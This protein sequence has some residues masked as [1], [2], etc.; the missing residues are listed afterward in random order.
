V[1]PL[2]REYH[3]VSEGVV[4]GDLVLEQQEANSFELT[5]EGQKEDQKKELLGLDLASSEGTF[6]R[7]RHDRIQQASFSLAAEEE[8]PKLHIQIAEHLLKR[9]QHQFS[10]ENEKPNSKMDEKLLFVVNHL[11]SG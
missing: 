9:Y 5:G 3:P 8:V 11:N 1:L 6:F 2:D 7:F 10:K 4:R